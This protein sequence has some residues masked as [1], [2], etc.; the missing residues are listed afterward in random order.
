MTSS[1]ARRAHQVLGALHPGDAVGR[2]ALAIRGHLRAAGLESEIFVG[3]VD[4]R[5]GP[6][7]RALREYDARDDVAAACI[8][9]FS[10]GAPPAGSPCKREAPWPSSTTT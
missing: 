1:R 3:F 9:H 2:E 8:Y 5:L 10:P 7:A 6:H 4:P